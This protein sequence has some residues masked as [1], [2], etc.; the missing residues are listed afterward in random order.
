[1]VYGFLPPDEHEFDVDSGLFFPR[2]AATP[3]MGLVKRTLSFGTRSRRGKKAEDA[4]CAFFSLARARG[5]QE[6]GGHTGG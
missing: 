2:V 4:R 6:A 3:K 5:G 1:M